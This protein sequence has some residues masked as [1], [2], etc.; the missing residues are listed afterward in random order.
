MQRGGREGQRQS[1]WRPGASWR[2]GRRQQRKWM[3][4][5]SLGAV[6]P[7]TGSRRSNLSVARGARAGSGAAG[8]AQGRRGVRARGDPN[9]PIR[10][11]EVSAG[12]R[13]GMRG[14]CGDASSAP[15][16]GPRGM[17]T[18]C[19]GN[20]ANAVMRHARAM[21]QCD[22]RPA[23]A[24]LGMVPC[25]NAPR[26]DSRTASASACVGVGGKHM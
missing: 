12:G 9:F 15:M 10:W 5:C 7:V 8:P 11:A 6:R 18:Q 1:D 24:A 20:A 21:R 4:T 3:L 25:A 16:R 2:A 26:I 22:S 13:C 14:Q 17:R 23:E 19:A